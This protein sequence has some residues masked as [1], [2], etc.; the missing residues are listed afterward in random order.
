MDKLDVWDATKA[1]DPQY[2]MNM[3][4]K[5]V[6]LDTLVANGGKCTYE[7][8]FARSEEVRTHKAP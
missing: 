8:L 5:Y 1:D 7:V 2:M 3:A 6:I 4:K